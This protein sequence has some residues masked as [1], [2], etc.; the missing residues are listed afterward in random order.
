M[1]D[2]HFRLRRRRSF[3]G[4]E[5]AIYS[6]GRR[7]DPTLVLC[8]GLGGNVAIWRPLVERF[9]S[10]CRLVSWDYRGLFRSGA[11]AARR[12]RFEYHVRDLVFILE[13]ERI[14]APVLVGWSMGVQLGF[15]LHRSHPD[16]LRALVALFGGA[17]RPLDS[18]FD[19]PL[20]APVLRGV[21]RVLRVLGDRAAGVAPRVARSE[22]V[23][24]AFVRGCQ[25]LGWMAETFDLPA[26]QEVAEAWLGL[27]LATY[28][29]LFEA[30][31]EHDASD[32]LPHIRTPALLLAGGRDR[33]TPS[34][35]ASRL[36][37]ALPDAELR[38]VPEATHF[39]LLEAPEAIASA[40]EDFLRKRGVL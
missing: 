26:F 32:L 28:A 23:V 22:L 25:R 19:S 9:A 11:S 18:A 39:G 31:A 8:N 12:Q 35:L 14:Q 10:R 15:E 20:A 34:R 17:G 36:A 5:L 7:D 2:G 21:F 3:D 40:V 29:E 27:D 24:G 37:E 13:R 30:L 16:R 38:L 1:V 6:A 33:F 4:T